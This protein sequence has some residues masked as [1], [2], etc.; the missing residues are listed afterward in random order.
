LDTDPKYR[1]TD[2]RP[3]NADDMRSA[4]LDR[5]RTQAP[6]TRTMDHVQS[7]AQASPKAIGYVMVLLRKLDTHNP[8][9]GAVAREW[10]N[11]TAIVDEGTG[12]VVGSTLNRDQVSDVINRLK[13]HLEAPGAPVTPSEPVTP[14]PV[15]PAT[16][17]YDKYDDV[18]DGNYAITDANGKNHFYR[19]SRREGKGQ[20]AGRT[21]IN[22]QERASED[23]FRVQGGWAV[24]AR[25]LDAIRTAGVEAAHLAYA[26]LL[27][28]CWHCHMALTDNTQPHFSRGLGPY[29]GENH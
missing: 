14:T 11:K 4:A 16:R 1:I 17:S 9:V 6:P 24:K 22:L 12:R 2:N 20:Y 7:T 29:C 8:S 27:K 21:F 25:I 3:A 28:R 26:T 10:W 23:L 18:T 15:P 19:V 13:G 5:L